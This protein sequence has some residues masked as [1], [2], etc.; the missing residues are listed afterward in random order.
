MDDVHD[1]N[2]VSGNPIQDD[3]V[4]VRHDLTQAGTRSLWRYR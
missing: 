1:L 2:A 4:W 3:V